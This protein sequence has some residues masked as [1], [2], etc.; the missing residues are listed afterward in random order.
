MK[1]LEPGL[2]IHFVFPLI[3]AISIQYQPWM[4]LKS[5]F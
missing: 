3:V 5:E 4:G 1:E 2:G